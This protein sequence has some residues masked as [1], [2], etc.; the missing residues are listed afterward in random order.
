[1]CLLLNS[2]KN[3]HK[4]QAK[5]GKTRGKK[6]TETDPEKKTFQNRF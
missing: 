5:S 2:V 3:S 6:I 4:N 1:M